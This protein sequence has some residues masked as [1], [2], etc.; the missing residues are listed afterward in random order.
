MRGKWMNELLIDC[1]NIFCL[2]IWMHA[3]I[4]G[5]LIY[6]LTLRVYGLMNEHMVEWMDE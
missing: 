3:W 6:W 5:W 4:N 1:I 2:Y